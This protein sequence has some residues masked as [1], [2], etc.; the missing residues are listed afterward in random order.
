MEI[1][2]SLLR[3]AP[4]LWALYLRLNPCKAELAD[5]SPKP[6]GRLY[7]AFYRVFYLDCSCC[8]ALRGLLAGFLLGLAAGAAWRALHA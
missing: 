1:F 4:R 2:E 6:P 8:S 7:D 3:R 5:G